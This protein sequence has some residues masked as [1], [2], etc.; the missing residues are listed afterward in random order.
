MF[1]SVI[2]P[3][4]H[5]TF[6]NNSGLNGQMLVNEISIG[7]GI[8]LA[9]GGDNSFVFER[10]REARGI[11]IEV[12]TPVSRQTFPNATA[13]T[14]ESG[15]GFAVTDLSWSP[16]GSVARGGRRYTVTVT[17]TENDGVTRFS[18]SSE[19][20]INGETV[21]AATVAS[22]S[23]SATFSYQF[24]GIPLL[25]RN[26]DELVEFRNLVN[27]TG[28]QRESF[29]GFTVRLINSIDL[30]VTPWVPIG[31]QIT[32]NTQDNAFQGTFDGNNQVV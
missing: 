2:A 32:P 17:L 27:G 6:N 10:F 18:S 31:R 11:E 23:R 5:L 29:E 8:N 22:D 1:G 26:L 21:T 24:P 16:A 30:G 13:A 7:S 25:I 20:I 4:A 3:T 28:V 15:T 12:P 9:A 14:I 19:A